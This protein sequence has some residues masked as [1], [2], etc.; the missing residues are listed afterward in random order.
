MIFCL[1][2]Y[3]VLCGGRNAYRV[4]TNKI[5]SPMAKSLT[6]YFLNPLII[7]YYFIFEDDFKC[8]KKQNPFF[9][10]INLSLSLIIVFCG[11]IYNEFI[12]L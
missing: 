1:F 8:G 2:L 3:F 10:A 12:V 9:F 7:S 6:D 11:C 5:Y 4:I